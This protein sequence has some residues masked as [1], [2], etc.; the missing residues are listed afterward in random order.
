M[1]AVAIGSC[2]SFKVDES[3]IRKDRS[4]DGERAPEKGRALATEKSG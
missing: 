2:L 3:G 4:P 1:V